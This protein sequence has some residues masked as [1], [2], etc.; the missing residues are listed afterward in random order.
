MSE[1]DNI[2]LQSEEFQEVLGDTPSWIL[3]WGIIL[4][5]VIVLILLAG[6]AVFKYPDVIPAQIVLTGT[7]PPASIVS[8]SSG[9]LNEMF[10]SDNQIVKEG[11]YLAVIDN[12]A[13]ID[14][15]LYL[16]NYINRL[17]LKIDSFQLPNEK[18]ILGNLQTIYSTFY[19][20]LFDYKE[21]K[22]LLY[23]PQKVEMTKERIIQYERQYKN[24][25][26]QQKITQEQFRIIQQQYRRDSALYSNNVISQ[27]EFEKSETNYFQG[28]LSNENMQSD[29]GNMEIQIAQLKES[30]LDTEQQAVEKINMLQTGL[31]SQISQIKTEIQNWEMNYVLLSPITGKITFN[32][33][34]TKNQNVQV[35]EEVFTIIPTEEIEVIGKAMLPIAR[36]GKVKIGQKVNIRID[37]FPDYEY[38]ML[39]GIVQNISLTPSQSGESIYYM[40]EIRFPE[41]LITTYR[42]ELP[43]LP[44][45]RGQ[46]DVITEN[47]SLFERLIMPIRKVL[48]ENV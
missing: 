4:L 5:A 2:E 3:R 15:I 31:Q 42:K 41:K 29:I 39:R 40:V 19:T 18:L 46:A 10:V 21:Y 17:N 23:Y 11:D 38:G 47:I 25:L 13:Q 35:G 28:L 12:P 9:K 30:L 43:Y 8:R 7:T 16:K 26:Q 33:Y 48:K 45:M 24:L 32:C 27:E 20:T 22:R 44:N 1:E 6:S 14:D 37:N 34:W 36:S